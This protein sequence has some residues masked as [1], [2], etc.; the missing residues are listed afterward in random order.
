MSET[1]SHAAVGYR[2][3]EERFVDGKAAVL[4]IFQHLLPSGK[5][6]TLSPELADALRALLLETSVY[7]WAYR[8]SVSYVAGDIPKTGSSGATGVFIP[9]DTLTDLMNALGLPHIQS[10]PHGPC[11][12]CVFALPDGRARGW[13]GPCSGCGTGH[14][15]YLPKDSALTAA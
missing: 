9:A 12:T 14:P 7:S 3:R 8:G 5:A 2:I 10:E 1:H 4:R 11:K 6:V 15:C 13:S